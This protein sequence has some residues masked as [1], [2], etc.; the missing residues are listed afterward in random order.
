MPANTGT[1]ALQGEIPTSYI[2]NASENTSGNTLLTL[3]FRRVL[4]LTKLEQDSM[5][6][7][8]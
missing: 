8:R 5:I 6:E 3:A 7:V 4:V 2:E 1:L